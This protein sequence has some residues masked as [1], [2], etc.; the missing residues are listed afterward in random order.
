MIRESASSKRNNKAWRPLS[1]AESFEDLAR[2]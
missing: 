1:S 2:N